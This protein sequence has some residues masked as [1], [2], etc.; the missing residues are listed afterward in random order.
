MK[1]KIDFAIKNY[2]ARIERMNNNLNDAIKRN[3]TA[4]VLLWKAELR[5]QKLALCAMGM[6]QLWALW[7]I[8]FG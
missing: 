5:F 7:H 4:G 6:F 2:H 1:Q 8:I 3:D